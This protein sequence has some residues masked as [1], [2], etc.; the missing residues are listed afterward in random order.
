MPSPRRSVSAAL[1]RGVNQTHI[2]PEAGQP[3]TR[4]SISRDARKDAQNLLFA[5]SKLPY[6]D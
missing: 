1:R 6:L 5:L 4:A 2:R 3:F